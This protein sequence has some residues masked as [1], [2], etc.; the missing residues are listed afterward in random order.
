MEYC[1]PWYALIQNA[2]YLGVPPWELAAQ[3]TFW[4][5]VAQECQAAEHY[6]D[7]ERNRH[8]QPNQP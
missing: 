5:S 6:A 4:Q 7:Q 2:K 8:R 1:P 3:P